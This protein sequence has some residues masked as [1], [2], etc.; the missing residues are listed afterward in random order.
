MW[1]SLLQE[2]Q[3]KALK[4]SKGAKVTANYIALELSMR[5][6]VVPAQGNCY[7]D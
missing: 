4:I 7:V 3:V 5:P 2:S 6:S 1:Q